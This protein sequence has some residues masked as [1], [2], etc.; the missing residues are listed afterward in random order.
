MIS[1]ADLLPQNNGFPLLGNVGII[2]R[3]IITGLFPRHRPHF[4]I[5]LESYLGPL[6]S[7]SSAFTHLWVSY[8]SHISSLFHR[9]RSKANLELVP[10]L[11]TYL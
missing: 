10:S 11:E 5:L 7:V 9:G 4:C 8:N 1:E 2:N 6:S 3:L